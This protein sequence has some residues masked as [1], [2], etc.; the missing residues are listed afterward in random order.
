MKKMNK[1]K[2]IKKNDANNH[3]KIML[4]QTKEHA[5]LFFYFF[6]NSNTVDHDTDFRGNGKNTLY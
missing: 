1:N 4:S 2:R 5:L 6:S 3:R